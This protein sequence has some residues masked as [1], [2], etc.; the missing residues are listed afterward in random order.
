MNIENYGQ[1][2]SEGLES[3]SAAIDSLQ[4]SL[5]PVKLSKEDNKEYLNVFYAN[6][7]DKP[8]KTSDIAALVVESV[9]VSTQLNNFVRI[10]SYM[11]ARGGVLEDQEPQ[12][13]EEHLRN[14]LVLMQNAI[15]EDMMEEQIKGFLGRLNSAGGNNHHYHVIKD[16]TRYPGGKDIIFSGIPSYGDESSNSS[17]FIHSIANFEDSFND[18]PGADYERNKVNHYDSTVAINAK[19]ALEQVQQA[20]FQKSLSVDSA[21]DWTQALLPFDFDFERLNDVVRRTLGFDLNIFSNCKFVQ[22]LQPYFNILIQIIPHPVLV[23]RYADYYRNLELKQSNPDSS[24]EPEQPNNQELLTLES[25]LVRKMATSI[26]ISLPKKFVDYISQT[27]DGTGNLYALNTWIA[28]WGRVFLRPKG[29][30]RGGAFVKHLPRY[31]I[32]ASKNSVLLKHRKDSGMSV[33]T[34][35]VNDDRMCINPRGLLTFMPKASD[36]DFDNAKDYE[37]DMEK[38]LELSYRTNS[39]LTNSNTL[40]SRA[41]V[42]AGADPSMEKAVKGAKDKLNRYKGTLLSFNWDYNVALEANTSTIFGQQTVDLNGTTKP[43][44]LALADYLGYDFSQEGERVQAKTFVDSLNYMIPQGETKGFSVYEGEDVPKGVPDRRALAWL[45]NKSTKSLLKTYLFLLQKS[46]ARDLQALITESMQELGIE[47]LEQNDLNKHLYTDYID[48]KGKIKGEGKDRE[49]SIIYGMLA[50][51]LED[52]SGHYGS[53]LVRIVGEEVGLPNVNTELPEH[54]SFF[55]PE[56][57]KMHEFGNVYTYLG[58]L[59][60]KKV[61]EEICNSDPRDLLIPL[62]EENAVIGGYSLPYNLVSREVYPLAQM[63]S[64]YVPNAVDIFEQAE[65]ESESYTMDES[66]DV[67]DIRMPGLAEGSQVFPHQIKAHKYLRKRPKYALLDIQPGGGKT[68]TLL[69]DIGC[70][71]RERGDIKAGVIAPDKLCGNWAED[72]AKITKGKWNAIPVTNESMKAWGEER[73]REMIMNAPPNTIIFIGLHFLKGS[74]TDISYGPR[75]LRLYGGAEFVKSLGLNYIA[76]DESHKAKKFDPGKNTSA[77]HNTCKQ[78]FTMQGVEYARLLTGT[79]IHGILEDAVGQSALFSSHIFRTPADFNIDAS[80]PDGAIRVRSKLGQH[81]SVIT[82]KRKEWAFML[83][84]PIDTFVEVK[85]IDPEYPDDEIFAQVYS[86]ILNQSMEELEATVAKNLRRKVNTDDEEEDEDENGYGAAMGDVD[87]DEDEELGAIGSSVFGYHMQRLEQLIID[88]WGD[89]AF[90]EVAIPANVSRNYVSPKVRKIVERL[91]RHFEVNDYD[92]NIEGLHI[93]RWEPDMKLRELD[94]VEHNGQRYMRRRLENDEVSLKRRDVPTSSTPPDQ[95]PEN[96]KPETFGKCL[97]FCRYVRTVDTIYKSLP[98]KYKAITRRFHSK[99]ENAWEQ[100]DSFKKDPD[101]KVLIANEQAITEGHNLQ[102]ASRIIRVETPWSPGDYEQSTARIFRPDPAAAKIVDGKPGDM[103]REVIYIDWLISQGSLEVAK[104]ARLMWKTVEKTKFDEKGNPR[105]DKVM[106]ITL[107]KIKMDIKTLI[108]AATE[109]LDGFRDHFYVKGMIASIEGQEFHEMRKT[110]QATMQDLPV[111]ES[112]ED[113][114][115]IEFLPVLSNQRMLDTNGHGLVPFPDWYGQW[116]EKNYDNDSDALKSVTDEQFSNLVR[117]LPVRT[118]FG[119]G[120]IVGWTKL[121]K[122]KNLDGTETIDHDDPISNFKVR[123]NSNDE[124]G[125]ISPKKTYIATKV[126]PADLDKFFS[127]NKP[128]STE[129]ERR[130]I[131]REAKKREEQEQA[132]AKKEEQRKQAERKRTKQEENVVKKGKK[133]RKNIAEGKPV[134]DGVIIG[135]KSKTVPKHKDNTVDIVGADMSVE[136]IP[137][138]YNGFLA[139]HVNA[140]DP[141]AKNLK[142]L[143]FKEFGEYAYLEFKRYNHFDKALDY[144]E[145]RMELDANGVKRLNAIMDVFEEK[146]GMPAGFDL[147]LGMKVQAELPNF[148]MTRHRESRNRKVIKLYPAVLPDRIR[149]TV[150]IATN[151]V[152]RKHLGKT[153]PGAG[154]GGKWKTHPGMSIFF[155]VNKSTAKAKIRELTKEGYTITNSDKLIKALQALEVRRTAEHTRQL[156]G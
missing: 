140:S 97:I 93:F 32:P 148:F 10:C 37:A 143:G 149:L 55:D 29:G 48:E 95:D 135:N 112:S 41:F 67:S 12:E 60:F 86:A 72:L 21:Q 152:I 15:G 85:L 74:T 98:P 80:A 38:A 103:K 92:P 6:T 44:P 14:R 87:F 23:S 134:N 71:Q 89:D 114:K 156:K 121:R 147:K 22:A 99:L 105:Y 118:E 142:K 96:W 150:D 110:T 64:N 122:V 129:G 40:L 79:F 63:F 18:A 68:I 84:T 100:I 125:N 151:P 126:T 120:I 155:A 65:I 26:G 20:I 117:K 47:S 94:V 123:F 62:E 78:I 46:K 75:K 127:T 153:I 5:A 81:A 4:D 59:V 116:K 106:E 107:P 57:S 141:D 145:D 58:G 115:A 109:G 49:V 73:L 11:I 43:S 102:M 139:L 136:I 137:S 53:N 56:R 82:V 54:P 130:A 119:T 108:K 45:Y 61:C 42:T 17:G 101:V 77:F 13:L 28:Q 36:I 113:F 111:E 25:A 7:N 2:S 104:V 31:I 132:K 30:A 76:L 1:V 90:K 154:P 70:C 88:P 27:T 138:V 124:I 3:S 52:A 34:G 66:V 51:A 83:P 50:Y 35:R 39:P 8:V 146:R 144:I 9:K 91:D 133:R 69:L 19:A 131:E 16:S 33:D 24:I 128:W